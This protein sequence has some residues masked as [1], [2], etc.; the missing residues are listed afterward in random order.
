VQVDWA[1]QHGTKAS[2][3]AQAGITFIL[4][5]L[6]IPLLQLKGRA[7][8]QWGG[9]IE[10]RHISDQYDHQISTESVDGQHNTNIENHDTK[11]EIDHIDGP[12]VKDARM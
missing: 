4:F 9:P 8:R 1:K 11:P 10:F 2:F 6:V 7:L 3:G 12:D 5:L